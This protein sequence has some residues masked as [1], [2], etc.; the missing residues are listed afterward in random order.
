MQQHRK[1]S[2]IDD[3]TVSLIRKYYACGQFDIAIQTAQAL[4]EQPRDSDRRMRWICSPMQILDVSMLFAL[5]PLVIS[6]RQAHTALN[7]IFEN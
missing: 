6:S 4:L 7:E 2:A 5:F 3:A 1:P